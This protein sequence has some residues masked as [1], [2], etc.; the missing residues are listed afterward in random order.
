MSSADI[1]ASAPAAKS[2]EH[3]PLPSSSSSSTEKRLPQ[4]AE[5]KP[6]PLDAASSVPLIQP[7]AI[8][9]PS[10]LLSPPNI[11][12]ASSSSSTPIANNIPSTTTTTPA[13]PSV[14]DVDLTGATAAPAAPATVTPMG[15]E[16]LPKMQNTPAQPTPQPATIKTTHTEPSPAQPVDKKEPSIDAEA[17]DDPFIPDEDNTSIASNVQEH[18]DNSDAGSHLQDLIDDTDMEVPTNLVTPPAPPAN[19]VVQASTPNQ[20]VQEAVP[21]TNIVAHATEAPVSVLSQPGFNNNITPSG[22]RSQAPKVMYDA[23]S[24]LESANA[25]NEESEPAASYTSPNHEW[26]RILQ[27]RLNKG[28]ND[29]QLA[30]SN[31][32]LASPS[33][34]AQA[35]TQV[36]PSLQVKESSHQSPS[37][38]AREYQTAE[39]L[40]DRPASIEPSTKFEEQPSRDEAFPSANVSSSALLLFAPL[41]P[42][43]L[44]TKSKPSK[45]SKPSAPPPPPSQGSA[46]VKPDAPPVSKPPSQPVVMP[47]AKPVAVV[48][49][50]PRSTAQPP[51]TDPST[52]RAQAKQPPSQTPTPT[53]IQQQQHQQHHLAPTLVPPAPP[54]SLTAGTQP[55]IPIV[56]STS[57]APGSHSPSLKVQPAPTSNHARHSP[58][59]AREQNLN[60][61]VSA[62]RTLINHGSSSSLTGTSG[63]TVPKDQHGANLTNNPIQPIQYTPVTQYK[64]NPAKKQRDGPPSSK[65]AKGGTESPKEIRPTTERSNSQAAEALSI[66]ESRAEAS[67][68][69]PTPGPASAPASTTAPAD[70]WALEALSGLTD[71]KF[72][73]TLPV[74]AAVASTLA[75]ASTSSSAAAPIKP[76]SLAVPAPRRGSSAADMPVVA[77]VIQSPFESN[78]ISQI[79]PHTMVQ[80]VNVEIPTATPQPVL[81]T[82]HQPAPIITG[83][84]VV[85]PASTHMPMYQVPS[86][87]DQRDVNGAIGY[88]H[89]SRMHGHQQG[90]SVSSLGDFQMINKPMDRASIDFNPYRRES[91]PSLDVHPIG[92]NST[93]NPA[94]NLGSGYHISW[95]PQSRPCLPPR[96][97]VNSIDV[98]ALT[99][100]QMKPSQPRPIRTYPKDPSSQFK[101]LGEAIRYWG[102]HRPEGNAFAS[103]EGKGAECGSMDW[104][105][106]LGRAEH[107][108][109]NIH[110]RTQLAPGARVALVYRLSEI[111]EF[112][113]AFY[114]A[115]IAG[116]VPVLVNQIQ[117]LSEM[118]Y[119]MTSANVELAL[120]TQ[121]NHKSL[122]NDG[123]KGTVWPANVTWWRTDS[124]E[125]WEP[126][127][128]EHERI[129]L[130]KHDMAYIEYTKS[131]NGELKG[132]AVS[133]KNL[134]VQCQ[135]LHSS[136]S[137]RPAIYRDKH[138]KYQA[139]P[140]LAIDPSPNHLQALKSAQEESLLPGTVMTWLEP[141]QQSGLLV[142]CIMGVYLG[143]F[144]VFVDSSITALSGLW[145]HSVSAYRANIVFADYYGMQRLLRN[146]QLKPQGTVTP[147]RPD[148]RFLH[149]VYV[150]APSSNP[151]FNR[152]F[153]D[154]YLYPLGMVPR[155]YSL[156]DNK[157]APE[158]SADATSRMT[159]GDL[160]VITFL[161]LPEHGG[162]IVSVRDCLDPL[163]GIDKVDFR[164][165]YRKSTMPHVRP[166]SVDLGRD[167]NVGGSQAPVSVAEP[168]TA[169]PVMTSGE[170]AEQNK[171]LNHPTSALAST[172]YL[173]QRSALRSNKVAVLATG[174]EAIRRMN[175]PDAILFGSFGYPLAQSSVLIVDPET[176][177]ISLPDVV[178][179]IWISSPTL[180]VSF[181]SL[182]EHTLEVFNAKPFIITEEDMVPSVYRPPKGHEKLLRT[183]LLGAMIEGRLVVFGPYSKRLQQDMADPLKPIGAQFEYHH[184]SDLM[185][186]L[187]AKVNGVGELSIFECVVNNEFL[188]VICIEL[189]KECRLAA[190]P[191]GAI[192]QSVAINARKVLKEV[193]GLRAYC[194]AVWEANTLPK[195]YENGRRVIDHA[196]CKR[197]FEL[198]RIFKILYFST[199]IGDVVLNIPRGDDLIGGFWSRDCVIKRLQ[200]QGTSLRYAQH[201]PTANNFEAFDEK[202]SMGMSKFH[203][204]TDVL[205][206]R[207]ITQQDETAFIELDHRGKEQ[208][209]IP[210]KKFNHKVT[211]CAMYL[212][213]K[214]GLKHGDHVILWFTQDLEYVVTLHACW[215]LGLIPIPLAL[216]DHI[217]VQQPYIA[218]SG[219]YYPM[220]SAT[221]LNQGGPSS[222][223][224]SGMVGGYQT[225]TGSQSKAQEER[226]NN[227]LRTLFRIMDE[228]RVKAILGNTAT[229]EY[230][231]QKSTAGHLRSVR[232]TFTP[233]FC[234]TPELVNQDTTHLPSFFNVT[235]AAKTKQILGALSGY[236]P[237]R[238]WFTPVYPAVYLIDPEASSQSITSRRLLKLTHEN[239]NNLCRNQKLQFKMTSGQTIVSCMSIFSGMGFVQGCCTGIYAG[240]QS[241]IIQPS[242]FSANP[243]IWLEALTRY[244]V[245]D[246]TLT[247]PLLE[248]VLSRLDCSQGMPIQGQVVLDSLKN[249]AILSHG[250]TQRDK[251]STAIARLGQYKMEVEA[252]N[253]VYSHP[254]SFMVTSQIDRHLGPVRIHVSARHLRYGLITVT[255][256]SDD[257]TGIWLEDIGSAVPNTSVVIVH[258]ETLEVCS[259]NQIG[260]IWVCAD[261]SVNSFHVPAGYTGSTQPQ[262]FGA[263][264]SGY[265]SRIRYIRTGDLGFLWNGQQQH[266]M[267]LQAGPS[268]Q[269]QRNVNQPGAVSAAAAGSGGFQLFVLGSMQ[270]AFQVHGL[271]HFAQDIEST[272][273]G[274]HANVAPQGCVAFTGQA[275]QI[276]VVVKVV[277]QEAEILVSMYIPVMHAVL[278]QHQ[279]IP[280]VIALV[281]DNVSTARRS[282]DGLKPRD[283]ISSLYNA[284][285]LPL[286]HLH[287][288][289]GV[290]SSMATSMVQPPSP[291]MSRGGPVHPYSQPTHL[292]HQH[293]NQVAHTQMSYSQPQPQPQH[294]PQPQ[295]PV[296]TM[297]GGS[298]GSRFLPGMNPAPISASARSVQPHLHIPT[299]SS[300]TPEPQFIANNGRNSLYG[301]PLIANIPLPPGA[302]NPLVQSPLSSTGQPVY[303]PHSQYH[304][305]GTTSGTTLMSG[306]GN[307]GSSSN[308]GGVV[309]PTQIKPPMVSSHSVPAPTA[310]GS[311]SSAAAAAAALPRPLSQQ[312]FLTSPPHSGGSANSSGQSFLTELSMYSS[313]GGLNATTGNNKGSSSKQQQQQRPTH[314]RQI[315]SVDNR[316][317][318]AEELRTDPNKGGVKGFM[319]GVNAKLTEIRKAGL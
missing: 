262:P 57:P 237:R 272:V 75:A 79:L 205:I 314:A 189:S 143:N 148:L 124:N 307:G 291:T 8:P 217:Q 59:I 138:G 177:A 153:L 186:T 252:I 222:F 254:L 304:P 283:T 154:E 302:H 80:G 194:I 228:V 209:S 162:A 286:L 127:K 242:D 63:P 160:G 97:D 190:Q 284:D 13:P 264:I 239:L 290:D 297:N 83:S 70:Q 197:M 112:V 62:G 234:Q 179:E 41:N 156:T 316:S 303:H 23:D 116:V 204:V 243:V 122:M 278:E 88:A 174:D 201:T 69:A 2:N 267:Q 223:N 256:E 219:V 171:L 232:S 203:T 248:Q 238:E 230:I 274:A 195:M 318:S 105:T 273:E 293:K 261:S 43:D 137:W 265:D 107:I 113:A 176:L 65:E 301:S 200:R 26:A 51:P 210:F 53:P 121:Y 193:N 170:S 240:C 47:V 213:R 18:S 226:R 99:G 287:H 229:D 98:P 115:M 11:V 246:A 182:P 118:V 158:P 282:T 168:R 268:N 235:K 126:K 214:C 38:S 311:M 306:G 19:G 309:S 191:I 166:M 92:S 275:G 77:K 39:E 15:T 279:L 35:L 258:P 294:Q 288:C 276:V 270:D 245:Q 129:P 183:G 266:L 218:S 36:I 159:R 111:L 277:S 257:P 227:I 259:S 202:H 310:P 30:R 34:I 17:R 10:T 152:E 241:V 24:E 33:I 263:C 84:P 221:G 292:N 208:K 178:G 212:D 82:P 187:H 251:I 109:K 12:V 231:R 313:G 300:S 32:M 78:R 56:R 5:P 44:G 104:S 207:T 233:Q 135:T 249:L 20:I 85:I 58:S 125:T 199:F 72:D 155:Q 37:S 181:W 295:P 244:K 175:D 185:S 289:H 90:R 220:N 134:M 206:W 147:T 106:I 120:T 66:V 21:T 48:Q 247:Y 28:L 164:K 22:G 312:A 86:G 173:L 87:Q 149:T 165:Q 71:F 305:Y 27:R 60:L 123:R 285:R 94:L 73:T 9:S 315:N 161:S 141:R 271:L 269:G 167:S 163:P 110:E 103:I 132:V 172:E 6:T 308:A 49:S 133:H 93:P 50:A 16:T 136:F 114:G 42:D 225:G 250:R 25:N 45:S 76:A 3:I 67:A 211:A 108:A 54:T 29:A 142:G 317:L 198:G 102:T 319:K 180:P 131:A 100:K 169:S 151:K 224:P 52:L 4:T 299:Y 236:G 128:G 215:A 192:A 61:S 95:L 296:S 46:N 260:E 298:S 96:A 216:P 117:E 101:H 281:G 31:S 74:S 81:E 40:F 146:F 280:D 196:L 130:Q 14:A 188:P 157:L 64:A 253:A 89:G 255:S 119:I 150:D 144:T 140:L 139:D 68:P 1:A 184:S 7:G 91:G 55:S 145:A